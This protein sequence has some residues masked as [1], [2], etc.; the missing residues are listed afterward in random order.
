MG[1]IWEELALAS[2]GSSRLRQKMA[3]PIW[4]GPFLLRRVVRIWEEVVRIARLT[5]PLASPN[6]N[7]SGFTLRPQEGNPNGKSRTT[8]IHNAFGRLWLWADRLYLF[9]V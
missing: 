2:D 6:Y 3:P 1:R 7:Q 4:V 8:G 9:V 5:A